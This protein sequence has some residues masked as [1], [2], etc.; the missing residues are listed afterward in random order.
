M[1]Y[2]KYP[3]KLMMDE[4][5]PSM[6][7]E[8]NKIISCCSHPDNKKD[9]LKLILRLIDNFSE[10]WNQIDKIEYFTES[11]LTAYSRNNQKLTHNV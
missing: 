3:A 5:F 9:H 4:S 7:Q 2:L 11:L 10:K 1:T 6:L 8:Y